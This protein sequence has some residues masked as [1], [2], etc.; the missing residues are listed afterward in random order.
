MAERIGMGKEK[1][2][3][4]E[5][6]KRWRGWKYRG[7]SEDNKAFALRSF[8]LWRAGLRRKRGTCSAMTMGLN[9]PTDES[10]P[11]DYAFALWGPIPAEEK[12]DN[13]TGIFGF[14]GTTEQ[15]FK[16]LHR[17][18]MEKQVH[19]VTIYGRGSWSTC[20]RTMFIR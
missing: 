2:K 3:G 6:I 16:R 14:K 11:S 13:V 19:D 7:F 18:Q 20:Y 4:F 1:G 15:R 17:L 8:H 9:G 10:T 5:E 12:L